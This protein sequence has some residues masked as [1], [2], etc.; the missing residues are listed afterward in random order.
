[1]TRSVRIVAIIGLLLLGVIGLFPPLQWPP[2][3]PSFHP[4]GSRPAPYNQAFALWIERHGLS[5]L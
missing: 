1:M 2:S 3:V 4:A 5:D